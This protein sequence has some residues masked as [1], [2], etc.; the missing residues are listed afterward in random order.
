MT[1]PFDE[2]KKD[3]DVQAMREA[4]PNRDAVQQALNIPRQATDR[5]EDMPRRRMIGGGSKL[6]VDAARLIEMGY[7]VYWR[8]DEDGRIQELL[9]NGYEFVSPDE[10]TE[11]N[12]RIGATDL[13]ADKVSRVVGHRENGHPLVAYLMKIKAG[14]KQEN[15]A[16]YQKR[17]DK[18]DAAIRAGKTIPVEEGY[19][20]D[21]GIS[22]TRS[23]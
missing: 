14:W 21:G 7:S 9:A 5:G 18:I 22:Y 1:K 19:V 4:M 8:N 20:P 3:R 6:G 16:F 12:L 17:C 15:D 2:G 13:S 11:T 23:R 10:I